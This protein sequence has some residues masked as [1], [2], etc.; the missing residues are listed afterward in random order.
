[1]PYFGFIEYETHGY[2]SFNVLQVKEVVDLSQT[3]LLTRLRFLV[4]AVLGLALL[5]LLRQL[6]RP[7]LFSTLNPKPMVRQQLLH[8][9]PLSSSLSIT[10]ICLCVLQEMIVQKVANLPVAA[11]HWSP[12]SIEEYLVPRT[13]LGKMTLFPQENIILMTNFITVSVLI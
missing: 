13:S 10:L 11:P 9:K 3:I 8:V 1:M 2:G 7:P 5:D 12:K 4:P 6:Q